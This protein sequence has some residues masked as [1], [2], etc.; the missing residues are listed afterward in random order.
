MGKVQEALPPKL[1]NLALTP[2]H[3]KG[4]L[5]IRIFSSPDLTD[6]TQTSGQVLR[7]TAL[8]QGAPLSSTTNGYVVFWNP[9]LLGC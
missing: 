1:I 9:L 6:D 8:R 4:T 5:K 2:P 3:E 7:L